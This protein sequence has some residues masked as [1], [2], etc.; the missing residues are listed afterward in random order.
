MKFLNEQTCN[1]F[2]SESKFRVEECLFLDCFSATAKLLA[3]LQ[4]SQLYLIFNA[5][6]RMGQWSIKIWN[7]VLVYTRGDLLDFDLNIT[8]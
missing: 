1:K 2:G 3:H 4:A 5:A 6:D 8:N 7:R